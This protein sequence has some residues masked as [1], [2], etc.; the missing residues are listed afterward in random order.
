ML[1]MPF[2]IIVWVLYMSTTYC[3]GKV[4]LYRKIK[5][6]AIPFPVK[7]MYTHTRRDMWGPLKKE[8]AMIGTT[9]AVMSYLS[10]GS[11]FTLIYKI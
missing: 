1:Y 5:R 3:N 11:S 4:C 8:Y 6:N 9:Y 7:G 10:W 2:L